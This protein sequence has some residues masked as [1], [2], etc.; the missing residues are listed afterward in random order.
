MRSRIFPALSEH[1]FRF[2]FQPIDGFLA[3]PFRPECDVT[4]RGLSHALI[5]S[6]SDRK[7]TSSQRS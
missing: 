5:L 1:A 4:F 3:V 7:P 6:Y 2:T